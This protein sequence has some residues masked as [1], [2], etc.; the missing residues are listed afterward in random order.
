MHCGHCVRAVHCA[1]RMHAIACPRL[2][3][4]AHTTHNAQRAPQPTH[5]RGQGRAG[6]SKRRRREVR[7]REAR[8]ESILTPT[9]CLIKQHTGRAKE[10]TRTRSLA[11]HRPHASSSTIHHASTRLKGSSRRRARPP[12]R[13]SPLLQGVTLGAGAVAGDP[14]AVR[15]PQHAP[16]NAQRAPQPTHTRG[17]G[18]G[19]SRQ[20]AAIRHA[21]ASM[22]AGTR[23]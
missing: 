18:Q 10:S 5:T 14:P 2:R 16:H 4:R 19:P 9:V 22:R 11:A 23:I 3:K 8:S 1:L 17:Q 20:P 15:P 13:P 12:V 7:E 21:C 6:T